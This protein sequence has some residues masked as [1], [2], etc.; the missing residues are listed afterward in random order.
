[1]MYK[2]KRRHRVINDVR[3]YTTPQIAVDVADPV[4]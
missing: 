3:T 2:R 1:M 4:V